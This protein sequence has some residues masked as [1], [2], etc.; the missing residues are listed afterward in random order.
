MKNDIFYL[1]DHRD[2]I[3]YLLSDVTEVFEQ[4]RESREKLEMALAAA[5]QASVAKT[6]F[7][8]RMSHEIRTPMNA[9]IGLD[10]IALQEKGI[11]TT[12]EDHLQ[13]IGISARFLLSLINDILDMSRIESGRMALQN[14]P[15][16]F[17]EMV[18]GINTILYEQCRDSGLDYEC[19]L[20]SYTEEAYT[21]DVTK[22]QQ[23]LINLLGNAVKFTPRGGKI[24]FMIEQVSRTKEKARLRFEIS[25]TGIG[26]DEKFLPAH[27][28]AVLTGKPGP[29]LRLRRHRAGPCHLQK[30]RRPHERRD[31]RPF[32]QKC[33]QRI[34]R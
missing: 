6:E 7:L 10:A 15:F 21:G 18:N 13:K 3:I 29:Y 14:E 23:V 9:I 33:G 31:H 17:E 27:V 19:V 11:S 1:D 12:M 25:D 20:K 4:E 8:S 16:N 32:H 30:H 24:H 22:L 34:Y 2:R 5:E 26:I 28:R